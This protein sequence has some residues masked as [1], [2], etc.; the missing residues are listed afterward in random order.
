MHDLTRILIRLAA[1]QGREIQREGG[2]NDVRGGPDVLLSWIESQLGL[3]GPLSHRGRRIAEYASLLETVS[4]ASFRESLNADR[5]ATASELLAR[6]DRLLLDAWDGCAVEGGPRLIRDLALVEGQGRAVAAG[7]ADRLLLVLGA[8]ESGQVLPPHSVVLFD[9]V[10]RWPCVWRKVLSRLNVAQA[11]PCV[12]LGGSEVSLRGVQDCVSDGSFERVVPDESLGNVQI[13]S[14]SSAVDFVVACLLQNRSGIPDTVVCCEETGLA[15][16]L[17][18]ALNRVGIP[19]MGVQGASQGHPLLQVL[20]STLALCWEP[21]DPQALLDF[22]RLPVSPLNRK[23]ARRLAV[24]L[25]EQPGLGS[26]AWDEAI[27][28]IA[29]EES[30]DGERSAYTPSFVI[31]AWLY[32]AR[33]PYGDQISTTLVLERCQLVAVWARKR[34]LGIQESETGL[35]SMMSALFTLADCSLLL[36]ELATAH[37]ERISQP[38]LNRLL[39]EV[40]GVGFETKPFVESVG[41]PRW[42]RSI[43][44]IVDPC[45]RVIWLGVGTPDEPGCSWSMKQVQAFRGAGIDLDDGSRSLSARRSS[46]IRGLLNVTRSLIAIELATDAVKRTHPL[47][48][49]ISSRIKGSAVVLD[50]VIRENDAI[51]VG[52]Y[53]IECSETVLSKPVQTRAIWPIDSSHFREAKSVSATELEVRIGCP[54]KWTLRYQADLRPSRLGTLPGDY[55][56]RGTFLHAVLERVFG[57]GESLPTTDAAVNAV[58]Q[59]FDERIGLDAAPLAQPGKRQE[60][61]ALRGELVKATE[62]LVRVLHRGEYQVSGFEVAVNGDIAGRPLSGRIDCLAR[63]PNGGEAIIDFKYGGRKK[64]ASLIKDGKSVQLAAYA[65]SRKCESNRFPAVA[66]LV[67]AD[68]LVYTPSVDPVGG[69]EKKEQIN[70]PPISEV[71]EAFEQAIRDADNWI[72]G[73]APVVAWPLVE[74]SERPASVEVVLQEKLA[75][76]QVQGVC[77]YCD[78]RVICGLESI[79]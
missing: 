74:S 33:V 73:A 10:D 56:L 15:M 36:G 31:E 71:W 29:A 19:P 21:V 41:G 66:Y 16:R 30:E 39:D 65:Y 64:Y 50:E 78:F 26:A 62:T 23:T 47:W 51:S 40:I 32:A 43:G 42:V 35:S 34:A 75:S 27:T 13:G 8:L 7:K 76:N 77:R 79:E 12:G 9:P 28:E 38:Q 6:R 44:E 11:E 54:L 67:L 72:I 4:D 58:C 68:S 61:Q 1:G 46:E 3:S 57:G 49:Q 18:S 14:A 45:Q 17:D 22:L 20:V 37:G 24:A 60:C 63:D 70:G 69:S 52:P 53:Q 48:L 59:V 25:S 5:W 2:S 55:Q